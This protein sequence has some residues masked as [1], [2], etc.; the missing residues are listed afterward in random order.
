M[1]I[2]TVTE[3]LGWCTVLNYGILIFSTVML[4]TRAGAW[5]KGIHSK[6]FDIPVG[7]LNPMYFRFLAN[8]KLAVFVFNL[9]PYVA[10]K[11][12]GE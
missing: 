10:L 12:V 3:F 5:V 9:V 11:I 2:S 7:D 6:L 1:N 8:Y 4:V